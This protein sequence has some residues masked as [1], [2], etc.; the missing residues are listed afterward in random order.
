M[1]GR[2]SATFSP[3]DVLWKIYVP[4]VGDVPAHT[5]ILG[6]EGSLD[7]G[8]DLCNG[9]DFEVDVL[10]GDECLLATMSLH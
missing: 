6:S 2:R 1:T 8:L 4:Q 7:H 10:R 9:R 5:E 3:G